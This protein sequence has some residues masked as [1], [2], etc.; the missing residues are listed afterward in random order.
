MRYI[1]ELGWIL[2]GFSLLIFLLS[3]LGL[4]FELVGMRDGNSMHWDGIGL[5]LEWIYTNLDTSAWKAHVCFLAN[6]V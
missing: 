6:K 1:I 4:L 3:V 5:G 2:L